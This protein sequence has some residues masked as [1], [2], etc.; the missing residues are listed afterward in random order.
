MPTME[1]TAAS[2]ADKYGS[3]NLPKFAL[4]N[5]ELNNKFH[6]LEKT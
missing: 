4:K 3:L 2:L 5:V 1:N 6:S